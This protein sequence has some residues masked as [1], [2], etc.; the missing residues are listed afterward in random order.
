[1]FAKQKD[2]KSA[3]MLRIEHEIVNFEQYEMFH[4]FRYLNFVVGGLENCE[5]HL[6]EGECKTD[7]RPTGYNPFI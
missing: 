1:M 2:K 3:L 5:V 6:C 4:I 7:G